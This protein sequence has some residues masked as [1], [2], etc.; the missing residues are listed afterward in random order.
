MSRNE[1]MTRLTN[2]CNETCNHCI[3]RS[4]PSERTH[5][6][7]EM[8]MQLNKWLPK[9]DRSNVTILGGEVCLIP[10]Y[11]DLVHNIMHNH[12]QG[13]IMTNGVFVK[14][15]K[16]FDRFVSMV[17]N[18]CVDRFTIRVSKSQYHS[19]EGYGEEAFDK[20]KKEFRNQSRIFI[21]RAEELS[22][23]IP[24]GRAYDNDLAT[25][26]YEK[27]EAMCD[28]AMDNNVFINEHGMVHWCP[29]GESPYKHFT[30][31]SFEEVRTKMMTW[32]KE[33]V[34]MGMTCFGCSKH[35]IGHSGP[36]LIPLR[37]KSEV[38]CMAGGYNS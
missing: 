21:Q 2:F 8:S 13:G 29:I 22:G 9:D 14:K 31:C 12:W 23:I 3:F 38:S 18:L 34:D 28:T 1:T 10:N 11:D 32:R 25:G 37:I 35:G 4:G 24:F 33:K 19:Q 5:M 15:Q 16:T 36:K 26:T 30:Q 6:T 27:K 20:L 17:R 7:E